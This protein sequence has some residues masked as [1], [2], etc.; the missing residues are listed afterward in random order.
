VSDWQLSASSSLPEDVLDADRPRV[1]HVFELSTV[2]EAPMGKVQ[3]GSN[4]AVAVGGLL[5][6]IANG[7]RGKGRLR[8]S[9]TYWAQSMNQAM[10]RSDLNKVAWVLM[11]ASG[12]HSI[13]RA[14][15]RNARWWASYLRAQT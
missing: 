10:D 3:I 11:E 1:E 12:D 15:R 2:V 7:A 14:Q 13:S 4:E 6:E 9:A 8:S 5:C